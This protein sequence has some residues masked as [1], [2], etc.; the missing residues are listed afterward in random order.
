[1]RKD[2]VTSASLVARVED[3]T[4]SQGGAEMPEKARTFTLVFEGDLRKFPGNFFKVDTA[5]GKP[6]AAGLGNAFD[7]IERLQDNSGTE[8][9]WRIVDAAGL[10][11][12]PSD[13]EEALRL[14]LKR[15]GFRAPH[16]IAE[17]QSENTAKRSEA[18]DVTYPSP[19][20][21]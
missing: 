13:E 17:T 15:G 11:D 14:I 20:Q 6:I 21:V 2:Y 5:F 16:P 8:W 3:N 10:A 9:F 19:S 1:M 18:T 4:Q 7:E 12:V